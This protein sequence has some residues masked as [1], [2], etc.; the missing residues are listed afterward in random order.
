[1]TTITD[2]AVAPGASDSQSFLLKRVQPALSGLNRIRPR[3]LRAN[4]PLTKN[5]EGERP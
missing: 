5:Q 1:M 2:A 3:A 4:Q